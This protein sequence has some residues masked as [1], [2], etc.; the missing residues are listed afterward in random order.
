MSAQLLAELYLCQ[1][2]KVWQIVY[3]DQKLT[4]SPTFGIFLTMDQNRFSD[5]PQRLKEF[6]RPYFIH[7]ADEVF[8]YTQLLRL[9]GFSKDSDLPF[10]ILQFKNIVQSQLRVEGI[11]LTINTF[12]DIIRDAADARSGS[13][14]EDERK[15]ILAAMNRVLVPQIAVED[16]PI[17]YTTLNNIFGASTMHATAEPVAAVL[18]SYIARKELVPGPLLEASVLDGFEVT[19]RWKAVYFSSLGQGGKSTVLDCIRYLNW[20]VASKNVVVKKVYPRA[21]TL[22]ELYGQVTGRGSVESEYKPGVMS[23]QLK[24][25]VNDSAP[26]YDEENG[27]LYTFLGEKNAEKWLLFDGLLTEAWFEFLVSAINPSLGFLIFSNYEK[28]KL[29]ANLRFIFV[30]PTLAYLSPTNIARLGRVFVGT[31]YTWSHA[32]KRCVDEQQERHPLLEDVLQSKFLPLLHKYFESL[33]GPRAPSLS[34]IFEL[35]PLDIVANFQTALDSALKKFFAGFYDRED[36]RLKLDT[37]LSHILYSCVAFGVGLLVQAGSRKAFEVFTADKLH[38]LQVLDKTNLFE[39]QLNH[40]TFMIDHCAKFIPQ[41]VIEHTLVDEAKKRSPFE[42]LRVLS[43]SVVW[44]YSALADIL[45]GKHNLMLVG[46]ARSPALEAATKALEDLCSS[47]QNN[48]LSICFDA[49]IE[50]RHLTGKVKQYLSAKSRKSYVSK[51]AGSTVVFIEDLNLPAIDRF[52]EVLIFNLLRCLIREKSFVDVEVGERVELAGLQ[53]LCLVDHSRKPPKFVPQSLRQHFY[54]AHL[55]DWKEDEVRHTLYATIERRQVL[56]SSISVTK[57]QA[58]TRR[59]TEMIVS[60]CGLLGGKTGRQLHC[61]DLLASVICVDRQY[62]TDFEVYSMTAEVIFAHTPD[63][64]VAA[65]KELLSSVCRDIDW[66]KFQCKPFLYKYQAKA[67]DRV[68][69]DVAGEGAFEEFV[70]DLKAAIKSAKGFSKPSNFFMLEE[71]FVSIYRLVGRLVRP[72]GHVVLS[73]VYGRDKL[74]LAR[75]ASIYLKQQFVTI[76]IVE[77]PQQLEQ[78]AAQFGK[79]VTKVLT[80]K[81]HHVVYLS[82]SDV[83]DSDVL[84]VLQRVLQFGDCEDLPID[85]PRIRDILLG[86]SPESDPNLLIKAILARCLR[87]VFAH[88]KTPA[89]SADLPPTLQQF[90]HVADS[91]LMIEVR[92]WEKDSYKQ[93]CSETF[94]AQEEQDLS[95]EERALCAETLIEFFAFAQEV[96]DQS[97]K[98]LGQPVVYGPSNFVKTC[99]YFCTFKAKSRV[100]IKENIRNIQSGI[101]RVKGLGKLLEELI[102]TEER[103]EPILKEKEALIGKLLEQVER[104]SESSYEKKAYAWLTQTHPSADGP[105]PGRGREDRFGDETDGQRDNAAERDPV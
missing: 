49:G 99:E 60:C 85:K 50:G 94:E 61:P 12:K 62:Q 14:F 53:Y 5:L 21:Y 103:L 27:R 93:V 65:V 18:S 58:V 77:G 66:E 81:L 16:K 59:C 90:R 23:I 40:N 89:D 69:I 36:H 87:L 64:H 19:S 8:V 10:L 92:D 55:P 6:Y 13:I 32:L 98:E 68:L 37:Y 91:C 2:K 67:V 41:E 11:P 96:A 4:V 35:T 56:S 47:G 74:N 44:V 84:R 57:L 25:I 73:S 63:D 15:V 1:K 38:G 31:D 45:R 95:K 70:A 33:F 30:S 102:R 46:T 9:S 78:F 26:F 48:H 29:P 101:S 82:I 88:D 75:V 51:S 105:D 80:E 3:A 71:V 100:E 79:V 22:E 28:Y 76:D 7:Q 86:G 39:R 52:D 17:Y 43:P 24:E 104:E 20:R 72:R 34:F 54:L 83:T 97:T 42:S